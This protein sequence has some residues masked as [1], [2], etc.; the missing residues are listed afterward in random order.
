MLRRKRR[1]HAGIITKTLDAQ[2][3][4]RQQ[5][6]EAERKK[7]LHDESKMIEEN[8]RHKEVRKSQQQE[9]KARAKK[10]F[11]QDVERQRLLASMKVP[12]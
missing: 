8:A 2:V 1:D 4:K 7:Q 11:D 12:L 6:V 10:A 9:W 3:A 5:Y